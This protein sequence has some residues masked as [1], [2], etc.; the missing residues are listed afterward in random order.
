[1]TQS[2]GKGCSG[3]PWGSKLC[4]AGITFLFLYFKCKTLEDSIVTIL[5]FKW[6]K[7]PAVVLLSFFF[8]SSPVLYVSNEKCVVKERYRNY[9]EDLF[10]QGKWRWSG[11]YWMEKIFASHHYPSLKMWQTMMEMKAATASYVDTYKEMQKKAKQSKIWPTHFFSKSFASLP[12][13]ILHCS[14]TLTTYSQEHHNHSNKHWHKCFHVSHLHSNIFCV[15][16]S[17]H[18]I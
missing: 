18:S 9:F 8:F 15:I 1:M 12:S 17:S 2:V 5:T 11:F 14:I 4:N 6:Q 13:F 7:I 16:D 10:H 3:G